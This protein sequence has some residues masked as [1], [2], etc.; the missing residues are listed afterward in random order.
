[1]ASLVVP[2]ILVCALLP[3]V[4]ACGSDEMPQTA[5]AAPPTA[6]SIPES[7]P[8]P[9]S[10]TT[11]PGPTA[12]PAPEATAA[13]TQRPAPT[14]APEPT[15]TAPSETAT[16]TPTSEPTAAPPAPTEQELLAAYAAGHAN[17]PGAIFAGDP[18]QLIGP[19]PHE[20]LMFQVPEAAYN[21]AFAAALFGVKELG[22]PSHLF[23]YTSDYYR[24]L[25]GKANLLNPTEL[26]SSGES[27]EIQHTCIDR[28]LPTCVLIQTYWAP[29]VAKRT[30][31]QV[32]MS[33]TSFLELGIS[34][35]DTLHLVADG[36]LGMT[37]IYTGHVA[38]EFPPIEVKSLWGLGS[39]V[40]SSYLSQVGMGPDI[41]RMLSEQTEGGF[42]VNRNWFAGADQWFF[43]E[44]PIQSL[45]DFKGKKVRTHAH[46]L[47]DLILGLGGEPVFIPPGG[48]YLAVQTGTVDVGTTGA[49]LAVSGRLHETTDYMTGPV[50]GFGYTNNVINGDFWNKIPSDLQEIIIE[51]GDK[52]ELEGL[53]LAP[54][55]NLI[56]V[57]INQMLG[58]QP[59]P[60]SEEDIR[61]IIGTIGQERI[62]PGW[63]GR[64]GYPGKN[65]DPVRIFNEHIGEYI[66][67]KIEADGSIKQV[68][69][70]KGPQVSQ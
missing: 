12:A 50:S 27:I 32:Q 45:E 48:H 60:F 39:S 47:T 30:N 67:L 65:E 35:A 43:S 3:A 55:Q 5:T 66:G 61:Y 57:Q 20:G 58:I 25:I 63:L 59:I 41:D 6:T 44:S 69:I 37:N 36:T 52:A 23:I 54:Y 22:I 56:A 29:N 62:I 40:E 19:P 21:Q 42:L 10:A 31:G 16:A 8:V 1:M 9:P 28:N 17:Q 46:A 70:T 7:T 2:V 38:G 49:L 53:R 24:E 68:P 34:G 51:E 14:A 15:P 18:M 33:L 11:A 13:P 64:L 26:T 4:T